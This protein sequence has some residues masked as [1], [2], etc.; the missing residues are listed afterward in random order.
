MNERERE[1]EKNHIITNW[2][3]NFYHDVNTNTIQIYHKKWQLTI[4]YYV[5]QNNKKKN[6]QLIY[7]LISIPLCWFYH[8]TNK[9]TNK[10]A[11]TN[12]QFPGCDSHRPILIKQELSIIE[13]SSAIARFRL[14]KMTSQ[15]TVLF[16]IFS[17]FRFF[18]IFGKFID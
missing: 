11:S 5:Y 8:K 9:Q 2:S 7:D 14:Y 16:T 1:R 10:Q 3:T 4:K 15:A 18:V 17:V 12:E 13:C 6:R